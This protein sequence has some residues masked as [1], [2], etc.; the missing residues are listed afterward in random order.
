MPYEGKEDPRDRE[1]CLPPR[2]GALFHR[3]L[4]RDDLP[5]P[6]PIPHQ[7]AQGIVPGDRADRGDSGSDR[8][9]A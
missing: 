4:K 8:Q 6:S 7:C 2:L 9:P 3:C 5:S 1:K